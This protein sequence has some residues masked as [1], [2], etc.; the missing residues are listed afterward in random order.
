MQI[1]PHLFPF[2]GTASDNYAQQAI[3]PV[4]S[5][6]PSKNITAAAVAILT[7]LSEGQDCGEPIYLTLR[8]DTGSSY[9]T[10]IYFD[11]SRSSEVTRFLSQNQIVE[12]ENALGLDT[13]TVKWKIP[14]V[15]LREACEC[16]IVWSDEGYGLDYSTMGDSEFLPQD[17]SDPTSPP[18]SNPRLFFPT[19]K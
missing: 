7:Y 1:R 3:G 12:Q 19:G 6:W 5:D 17:G 9:G 8:L 10:E 16:E 2:R 11:S 13:I 15:L 4:R 14:T 18:S